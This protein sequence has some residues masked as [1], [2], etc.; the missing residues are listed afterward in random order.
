MSPTE[1]APVAASAKR[2]RL[3]DTAWALFCQNG[4]RAVGIDTVLAKAGVAKR[5]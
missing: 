1:A 5:T 4:Y 2:E 3:L